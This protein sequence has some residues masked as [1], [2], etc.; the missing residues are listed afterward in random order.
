MSIR[1]RLRDDDKKLYGGKGVLNAVKNVNVL[2][3]EKLL[4]WDVADQTGIDQ[5]M[6]TLDGTSNKGKAILY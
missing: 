5:M 1:G 6:I 4:G 3:S 2:V